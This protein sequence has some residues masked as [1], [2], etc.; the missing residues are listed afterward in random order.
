MEATNPRASIPEAWA[1]PPPVAPA[2][3]APAEELGGEDALD[4]VLGNLVEQ[5]NSLPP[6]AYGEPPSELDQPVDAPMAALTRTQP[7]QRPAA[8]RNPST[9]RWAIP[10]ATVVSML[11]GGAVTMLLM[12]GPQNLWNRITGNDDAAKAEGNAPRVVVTFD[13]PATVGK[14]VAGPKAEALEPMAPKVAAPPPV[15]ETAAAIPTATAA[16]VKRSEPK[17]VRE[18]ARKAKVVRKARKAR[19]AK[20]MVAASKKRV[21]KAAS[22]PKKGGS[23]WEDP[24]K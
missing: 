2:A 15:V 21:K 18:K 17:K 24:Y 8:R 9:N 12:V 11:I 19:K 5:F 20:K 7:I 4:A 13:K 16:P 22:A 14:L 6:P 1:P 23:D 10:L 3:P